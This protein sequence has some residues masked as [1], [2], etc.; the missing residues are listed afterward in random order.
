MIEALSDRG[1]C[2]IIATTYDLV[3]RRATNLRPVACGLPIMIA[4][5]RGALLFIGVD[6]CVVETG[7]VG[8]LVYAPRNVLGGLGEIGDEVRL[9]THLHIREDVLALYGFA[10]S[11][12]RHLFETLLSVSG[13]GPKVALSMLSSAPTGRA[14]RRDRRRRHC[15]TGARARHRQEDRRAAGAGAARQARSERLAGGGRDTR[16]D[17]GQRRAGRDAGR[18]WASAPPRPAPRS[19]R[20]RPTPPP[21]WMSACGWRCAILAGA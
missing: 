21:S 12:Q 9:Y 5:I 6:H 2:A 17:G 10:T 4:S 8:F 19:P 14:A 20:C 16:A 13:V 11:D 3:A 1:G 15:A 18:A 7:G